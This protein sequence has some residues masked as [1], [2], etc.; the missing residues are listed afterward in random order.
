VITLTSLNIVS[1]ESIISVYQDLGRILG[2]SGFSAACHGTTRKEIKRLEAKLGH[3]LPPDLKSL[4]LYSDGEPLAS[5]GVFIGIFY[6]YQFIN[7]RLVTE[8]LARCQ[9]AQ[10]YWEQEPSRFRPKIRSIPSEAIRLSSYHAEW[11]PFAFDGGGNYLAV[12]FAPGSRGVAGQ[13]I[14]F[15]RDDEIH[16]QLATDFCSFL[17]QIREEYKQY[18]GHERFDPNA[19]LYTDLIAK[20]NLDTLD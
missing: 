8:H 6:S 11:I 1:T 10:A 14:N 9:R 3:L 2:F 7:I 4:Y 18:K 16:F 19:S 17:L 20:Y 13:I 15:G 5:D 12:D